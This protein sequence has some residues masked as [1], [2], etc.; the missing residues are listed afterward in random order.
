MHAGGLI[1]F[2][3]FS[4]PLS[5]PLLVRAYRISQIVVNARGLDPPGGSI[6]I[7][8]LLWPLAVFVNT[9]QWNLGSCWLTFVA[10]YG[11]LYPQSC[12]IYP[13]NFPMLESCP[14]EYKQYPRVR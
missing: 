3:L 14:Y 8:I 10:V 2:F 7:S 9:L 5:F 11:P 4:F 1:I 12:W 6:N 13:T